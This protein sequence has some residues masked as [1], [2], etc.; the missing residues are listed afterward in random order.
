VTVAVVDSGVADHPTFTD[1]QVTHIDLV[2]DGQPFDGHGTAMASLIAGSA[3]G[4]DGVSPAA[5][6][7]DVRV[8]DSTGTSNS[9]LLAEGIMTAV[10]NGAQ[11]INISMGSF[12]DAPAVA[13]AVQTALSH[14]IVVV[15][16][17]GNE[18]LTTL[19]WPAAYPG[20]ISVS[21]VDAA[22]HIAYF[23]NAGQPTLAA[24]AVGIPSAY[25]VNGQP[26]LA[27]GDGTSQAAALVSGSAAMITSTGGNVLKTL[28]QSVQPANAPTA[29]VGAGILSLQSVRK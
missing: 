16:S 12:G 2:N 28:T 21:G 7:L 13:D 25:A 14:G 17:A 23:S 24:P 19:D 10:Q 26:Y 9:F 29:Q 22:G 15:A 3:P 11:V 4:A 8:S 6:I 5:K 20:V 1:G 27:Q 18:D